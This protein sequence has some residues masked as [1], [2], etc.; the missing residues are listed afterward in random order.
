MRRSASEILRNLESRI[1][2][3]EKQSSKIKE[4][5]WKL[6]DTFMGETWKKEFKDSE[7]RVTS[8]LLLKQ[9]EK[10][11]TP[12]GT[13]WALQFSDFGQSVAQGRYLIYGDNSILT[14]TDLYWERSDKMFYETKEQAIKAS[15][16]FISW[17]QRNKPT[18]FIYYR[19]DYS[20]VDWVHD[21]YV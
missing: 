21:G 7:G 13:G 8:Y 14:T 2:R 10:T 18:S 16:K 4:T 6:E 1:A 20:G 9:Y 11:R 3:L 17:L 15:K 12:R 5:P 19:E